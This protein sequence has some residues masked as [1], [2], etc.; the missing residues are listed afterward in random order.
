MKKHAKRLILLVALIASGCATPMPQ[1]F[2]TLPAHWSTLEIRNDVPYERAWASTVELL[3]L[4]FD[5]EV[6][7]REDGYLRTAW[8]HTWNGIYLPQYRVRVIVIFPQDRR[9][10]RVKSEAQAFTEEFGWVTGT[11]ERLAPS[12]KTELLGTIGRTL[13]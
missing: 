3:A 1:G 6:M 4:N 9:T 5:L 10:I 2:Q 13:R 8:S 12:L 7:S 11:D